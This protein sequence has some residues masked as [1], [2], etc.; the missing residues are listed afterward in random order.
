MSKKSKPSRIYSEIS[1]Y[2]LT[3]SSKL[4][5]EDDPINAIKISSS[6]NLLTIASNFTS[7]GN[8]REARR[9]ITIA[10]KLSK[11]GGD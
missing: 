2:G 4:L 1:R 8:D 7:S 11:S 5:K 10:K 9:M 3:I 6:L